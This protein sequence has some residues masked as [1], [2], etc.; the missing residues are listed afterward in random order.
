MLPTAGRYVDGSAMAPG[1][2]GV[3]TLGAVPCPALRAVEERVVEGR[4]QC[5]AR[6]A[7]GTTGDHDERRHGARGDAHTRR[8]G[9]RP[10]GDRPADRRLLRPRRAGR[11]VEPVLPGRGQSRAPPPC[12]AVVDRGLWRISRL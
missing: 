12:D 10:P 6:P 2:V 5:S 8:V 11:P 1:Y 9:R 4:A 3:P 7:Y